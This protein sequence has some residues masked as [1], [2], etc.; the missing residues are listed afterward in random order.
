MKILLL[1]GGI[2][3]ALFVLVLAAAVILALL[4]RGRHGD[5]KF[6]GSDYE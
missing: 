5:S 3:V 4:D 6:P 2:I 1:I